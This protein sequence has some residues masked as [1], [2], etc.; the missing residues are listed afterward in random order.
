MSTDQAVGRSELLFYP[1]SEPGGQTTV[2]C[3]PMRA[4]L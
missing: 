4:F 3:Q 1:E 2:F